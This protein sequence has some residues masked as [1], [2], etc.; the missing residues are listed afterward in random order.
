MSEQT[1]NRIKELLA[2]K[3]K[4]NIAL[5]EHL[6]VDTR[7]VSTWCTNSSQPP[8]ATLFRIARFLEVEAGELL[9]LMKDLKPVTRKKE[10]AKTK[11]AKYTASRKSVLK[12]GASTGKR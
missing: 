6:D 10:S 1:F 2:K 8:V 4:Q 3:G 7:T 11:A 12:K 9:T 5:A